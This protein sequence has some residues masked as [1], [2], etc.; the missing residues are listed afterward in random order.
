M[1]QGPPSSS[2]DVADILLV[3]DDPKNVFA[4]EAALGPLGR[5]LVKCGNGEDALRLLLRREFALILLDVQ[6]PTIDGFE[7]ARLIRMR[8]SRVPVPIIFI[9]AFNQAE[10]DMRRGYE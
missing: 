6:L 10:T 9:T 3:D 2:P 5:R 1:S 4:I 7:T 8:K